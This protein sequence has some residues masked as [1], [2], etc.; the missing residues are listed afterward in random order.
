MIKNKLLRTILL[1]LIIPLIA[2]VF[3]FNFRFWESLFFKK[4]INCLYVQT[5]NKITIAD[6]NEPVKNIYLDFS[7]RGMDKKAVHMRIHLYDEANSDLVLPVTEVVPQIT[8]SNYI[9]IYPDGNVRELTIEFDMNEVPDAGGIGIKLNETRPFCFEALRFIAM[10]VII[11]LFMIFR[12]GS[13]IYKM[14]L[15][16][17][18]KRMSDRN[19]IY[20]LVMLAS[21]IC[22][23]VILVYAFNIDT[24]NYYKAG[25]VEAIYTYQAESLLK[26]HVWLDYDPPK[27][28]SEME[29][30]YDFNARVKSAEQAGEYFKLDF[31]FFEGRYY[32]YYGIV[33]T[34]LFYLPFVA[35]TGLHLNNSVPVLLM[36]IFYILFSFLL[37]YKIIRRHYPDVSLGV[38]FLLSAVFVFGTGAFYCAGSP[39]IYSVAFIA[40]LMFTVIALY[41]WISASDK[42]FADSR[43]PLSKARLILGAVFMGLAVGSRP[44]FGLYAF[45]AFPLF[46]SEIK[47]K[48][49]FS[50]KGIANTVC[51]IAPLLLI[52]SAILYFNKIR[53]GSFFDF[54]NTYNLSEMDLN[55]RHLGIRRLWLGFFEYLFQPLKISGTFPYVESVYDY[56]KI[57]TDYMGY[58]FFDPVF[59]GYF[60]L[61]PVCLAVFFLKKC[62]QALK[63]MKAFWL[64]VI[65]LAFAAALLILDIEL[66][67]I[68]LRY[69]MDFGMLIAIPAILILIVLIKKAENSTYKN[70]FRI[71]LLAL[72]VLAGITVFNNLF[73]MLADE[74]A[75]PLLYTSPRLYYSL[76][77]LVFSLR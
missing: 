35:L 68:T 60:A 28:L 38:Y 57:G 5:G 45:L 13:A 10:V 19:K 21:A 31:A 23:W 49:F 76:K 69:Q 70:A 61:C 37:I 55:N 32:S 42:H 41:N 30:P 25:H 12:P 16:G 74:K 3:F 29:N 56:Q 39:H 43:K 2:E 34:L 46:Y 14:P 72:I 4:Q 18:D 66:T 59:G 54:G 27:Y 15:C 48:L 67:G 33:P 73:I 63:D 6:I 36:G 51:V 50:K 62:K 53:F 7:N 44:V 52:G 47:D 75:R 20:T 22:L 58:M 17:A 77:Y 1:I 65:S 71:M 8:E 40:A 9:R 11:S 26:G 64:C 24:T